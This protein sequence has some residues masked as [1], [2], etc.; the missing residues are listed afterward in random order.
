MIDKVLG[1]HE[2]NTMREILRDSS[3]LIKTIGRF[4][5]AFVPRELISV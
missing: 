3:L 4:G 2:E 5:L 1:Y